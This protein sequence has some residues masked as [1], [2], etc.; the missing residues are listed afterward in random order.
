ME[1]RT[2]EL[3]KKSSFKEI[4][5]DESHGIN[6]FFTKFSLKVKSKSSLLELAKI[7]KYPIFKKHNLLS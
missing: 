7:L 6:L 5:K 3:V 4:L 1:N 2:A